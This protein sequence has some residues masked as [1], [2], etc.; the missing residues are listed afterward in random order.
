MPLIQEIAD[1]FVNNTKSIYEY[2]IYQ[3]KHPAFSNIYYCVLLAYVF[4][5]T[6]EVIL[7]KQREHGLLNRKGF[8]LDTFYVFF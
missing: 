5:F 8:W 6:L 4:C 2:T 1:V 3:L 7:P